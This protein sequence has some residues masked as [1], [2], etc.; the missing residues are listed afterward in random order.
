MLNDSMILFYPLLSVVG[1]AVGVF[2]SFSGLGGAIVLTPVLTTVFGLPYNASIGCTLAQMVGMA[3]AGL[4]RH[5]RLGHVDVKLAVNFVVGSVPGAILG[6]YVLQYVTNVYG[7]D[8]QLKIAF[9]VFYGV[10][11]VF[12]GVAVVVK[13]IRF[14]RSRRT[15]MVKVPSRLR[16]QKPVR[17]MGVV[18]VGGLGAGFLGGF[19]AIG[20]GIVTVPILTTL[21]GVSIQVAVGTSV[22]QMVP[23]GVS[24]TWMSV[25]TA[26]LDWGVIGW[27]LVG[28]IPGALVGPWLLACLVRTINR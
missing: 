11:L 3:A 19:L 26:D 14:L 6:R 28:S 10:A 24:A 13:V 5:Y 1:F 16:V 18:F 12:G 9:D 15:G 23:M 2:G 8:G 17:R 21:L 25:G 4:V 20:G 27:L 7:M 22:F